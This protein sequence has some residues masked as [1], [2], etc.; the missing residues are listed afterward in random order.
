MT[1]T[2]ITVP[3]FI[4]VAAFRYALGRQSV[5]V[6]AVAEE[7]M[8]HAG[9]LPNWQRTQ[10]ARDI[11]QAVAAGR[12]GAPDDIERWLVVRE[13]M[14]DGF[15]AGQRDR[16]VPGEPGPAPGTV[17]RTS[18]AAPW[19]SGPPPVNPMPTAT[20]EPARAR[21]VSTAELRAAL[22][23]LADDDLPDEAG[24]PVITAFSVD[25]LAERLAAALNT[26][27]APTGDDL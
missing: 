10:I 17:G 26:P 19:E 18:A 21:P 2:M 9:Q 14:L 8:Q 1:R 23:P 7:L 22:L 5:G 27:T 24:N 11:D 6:A 25:A 15:A 16:S 12:A 4:L 13:A 20:V 3:E